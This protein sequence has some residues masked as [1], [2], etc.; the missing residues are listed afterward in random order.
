MAYITTD[1]FIELTDGEL[2]SLTY[3]IKAEQQRRA[4]KKQDER[5]A[6]HQCKT[7]EDIR[8]CPICCIP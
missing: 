6:N 1:F 2:E 4:D 7:L 3:R 8:N 5:M